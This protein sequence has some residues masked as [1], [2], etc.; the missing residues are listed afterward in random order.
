MCTSWPLNNRVTKATCPIVVPRGHIGNP[1]DDPKITVGVEHAHG[2]MVTQATVNIVSK[3]ASTRLQRCPLS[4]MMGLP[5]IR[6]ML[7][8]P[9]YK[10]K[11]TVV[12]ARVT[13]H[14]E[15]L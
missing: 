6:C 8:G 2:R 10:I 14:C 9:M 4:L 13:M 11:T 5:V 3:T 15:L 1:I 12:Q 7:S